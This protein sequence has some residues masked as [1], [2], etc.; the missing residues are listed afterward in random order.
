M[1]ATAFFDYVRGRSEQLPPG[2][3]E[4]GMRAYRHLVH[5]G[6]AQMVEACFPDLRPQLGE[7]AWHTLIN[8]FVR[9][10][11]W[12]SPYYGDLQDEF[13]QFLARTSAAPDQ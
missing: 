3:G 9:E 5:L 8:A 10:S 13:T 7:D 2:Y 6:A 4:A 1:P 12:T 11:R